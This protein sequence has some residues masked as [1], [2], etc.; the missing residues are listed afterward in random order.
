MLI[1]SS[2]FFGAREFSFPC[3]DGTGELVAYEQGRGRVL[4][5][6]ILIGNTSTGS[7]I[8]LTLTDVA[9]PPENL[10]GQMDRSFIMEFADGRVV[11]RIP[12]SEDPR[13]F[14]IGQITLT[15]LI[16][17]ADVALRQQ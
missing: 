2:Q 14:E 3:N 1:L 10:D 17:C 6:M 4:S 7:A 15:D 13:I 5:S 16:D 9:V 8:Y 12:A 11:S